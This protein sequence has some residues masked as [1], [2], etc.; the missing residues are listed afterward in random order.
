MFWIT[1]TEFFELHSPSSDVV[2]GVYIA[3]RT[4]FDLIEP[5]TTKLC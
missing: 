1:A 3:P 5:V 4:Q 2:A